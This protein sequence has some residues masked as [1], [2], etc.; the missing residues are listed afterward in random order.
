VVSGKWKL[1][2]V[3]IFL[4]FPLSIQAEDQTLRCKLGTNPKL[5]NR[6]KGLPFGGQRLAQLKGLL[7]QPEFLQSVYPMAM[8]GSFQGIPESSQ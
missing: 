4:L 3:S 7:I 5:S 6:R 8:C 2:L 1:L